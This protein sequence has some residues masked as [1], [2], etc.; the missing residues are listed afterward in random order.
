MPLG[1]NSRNQKL[2]DMSILTT[3]DSVRTEGSAPLQPN[4]VK[5]PLTIFNT[6]VKRERERKSYEFCET[7]CLGP[8][9][10]RSGCV[11]SVLSVRPCFCGRACEWSGSAGRYYVS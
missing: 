2:V 8:F 11:K 9:F 5:C 7:F 1:T 6:L 3:Y 10:G 4:R